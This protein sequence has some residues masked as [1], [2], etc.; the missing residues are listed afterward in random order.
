MAERYNNCALE[1]VWDDASNATHVEIGEWDS[2]P[3]GVHHRWVD[4]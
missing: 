4:H 3:R 1:V 2:F